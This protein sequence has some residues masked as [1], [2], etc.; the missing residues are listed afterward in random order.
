MKIAV[1]NAS[2]Q[3]DKN[4]LLFN[5]VSRY[6]AAAEVVN[7]GCGKFDACRYSYIEISVLVGLL[8]S[9]GAADFVVTGC[10]SGQGM[11]L[12]CNSM[13]D[14]ICGYAPTPK[15]AYLFVQINNGNAISLPLGEEYTWAGED[16]LERT[17]EKLFSE[18]FGQGYP[19]SEAQ[20]KLRDTELLKKIRSRS[21]PKMTELLKTLDKPL[22][23][24][25]LSKRDAVGYILEN[26]RSKELLDWLRMRCIGG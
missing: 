2:S 26:G 11:M 23:E 24:K 10:S 14:V 13:P 9:S 6:A 4:E 12:A 21:Q 25:A 22:L 16:N 17:V 1:I 19:K 7:L 3:S 20:R 8:L 15:D 5:T 18:P